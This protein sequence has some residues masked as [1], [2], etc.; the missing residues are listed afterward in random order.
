ME[1]NTTR[2]YPIIKTRKEAYRRTGRLRTC[3]ANK[4]GPTILIDV[5]LQFQTE[6]FPYLPR[7]SWVTLQMVLKQIQIGVGTGTCRLGRSA[8]IRVGTGTCR[9]AG[10]KCRD[11]SGRR[12]AKRRDAKTVCKR[13]KRRFW[14]RWWKPKKLPTLVSDPRIVCSLWESSKRRNAWSPSRRTRGAR[15]TACPQRF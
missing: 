7:M 2:V 9:W 10:V 1:E 11:T 3:G 5:Q 8:Q 14:G 6:L 15:S 13:E 12:R 4:R